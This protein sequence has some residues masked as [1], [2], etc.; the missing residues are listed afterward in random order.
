ML[1]KNYKMIKKYESVLYFRIILFLNPILELSLCFSC[2]NYNLK[3]NGL[4]RIVK[5]LCIQLQKKTVV[6]FRY[7][8]NLLFTL[9]L[10]YK[11]RGFLP[12][13]YF[14]Y[15]IHDSSWIKGR[16]V[17]VGCCL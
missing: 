13:K 10:R 17:M 3:M 1:K 4:K 16:Q 15:T 6:A 7:F 11:K 9:S 2:T 12:V 8:L 14:C 5:L